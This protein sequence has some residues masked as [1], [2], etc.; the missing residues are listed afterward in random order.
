MSRTIQTRFKSALPGSGFDSSGAAR[1]GKR[2]VVGQISVTAYG[3][4]GESLTAADLGLATIDY[5]SIRHSDQ[6]AGKEG[7]E[8][9]VVLYNNTTS[10][11]YIVTNTG[12]TV[13]AGGATNTL[14]FD[15]IGDA[16]DAPE[17]T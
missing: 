2:R 13:T 9:R 7:K 3:N 6:A 5:I 11:F 8:A 1:Q 17:L 14:Q 12:A 16:L 15:A 4:V 10:D